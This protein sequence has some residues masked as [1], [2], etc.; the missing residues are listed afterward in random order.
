[1]SWLERLPVPLDMDHVAFFA[2]VALVLRLLLPQ[3]PVWRLSIVLAVL[4][5][6]TELLQ[7][8]SDGRTPRVP[9]ARDDMIGAGLG[10]WVAGFLLWSWRRLATAGRSRASPA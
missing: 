4:A 8:A 1:M 10:L 2:L 7:F 9:D 6:G 3:T 5:V